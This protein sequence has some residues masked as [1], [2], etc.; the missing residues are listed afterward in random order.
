M[1]DKRTSFSKI[2]NAIENSIKNKNLRN[3]KIVKKSKNNSQDFL[4][5]IK[6]EEEIE[7][8]DEFS[9]TNNQQNSFIIYEN[10]KH[11]K[12]KIDKNKL[13]AVWATISGEA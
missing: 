9:I 2:T 1:I 11:E 4:T 7:D 3:D 6:C 12:R 8:S 13:R 5:S 10:N